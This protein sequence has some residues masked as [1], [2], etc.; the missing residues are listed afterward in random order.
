MAGSVNKVILVGNLG[1]DPEIRR[2]QDGRPIANLSIATSDTWRDKATG[3]RFEVSAVVGRFEQ[4]HELSL[5][6]LRPTGH[7]GLRGGQQLVQGRWS[8]FPSP[9]RVAP[10]FVDGGG[11]TRGWRASSLRAA[12]K[13]ALGTQA[14]GDGAI[15]TAPSPAA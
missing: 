13:W 3:E 2:T 11:R 8:P 14:E 12:E 1:R 4:V 10:V 5:D 15:P 6:R 9:W 7:L